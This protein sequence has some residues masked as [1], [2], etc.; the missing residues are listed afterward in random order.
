MSEA[1]LSDSVHTLNFSKLSVNF[2][3]LDRNSGK[4]WTRLYDT[5][6]RKPKKSFF[7]GGRGKM[8]V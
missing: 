5:F 7:G 6:F 3:F 4:L 1:D 8:T 2:W